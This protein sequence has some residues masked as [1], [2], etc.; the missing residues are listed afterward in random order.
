MNEYHSLVRETFVVRLWREATSPAWR[1][2]IVHLPD[3]ESVAFTTLV[4]VESFIHRF[5]PEIR[6]GQ[7]HPSGT[8]GVGMD[9]QVY[10]PS[11]SDEG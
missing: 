5:V 11:G 2:Q 4:E 1:G 10:E 3:Q 7:P 8:P 9:S 6:A